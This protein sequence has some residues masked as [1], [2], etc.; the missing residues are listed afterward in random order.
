MTNRQVNQK[1]WILRTHHQA[2]QWKHRKSVPIKPFTIA[3]LYNA[4]FEYRYDGKMII[5]ALSYQL[6]V[7]K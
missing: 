2:S 6:S 1:N 5:K 7:Y 4:T 3:L